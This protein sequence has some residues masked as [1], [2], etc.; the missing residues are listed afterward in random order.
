L[1]PEA[2]LKYGFILISEDVGHCLLTLHIYN[3]CCYADCYL[4]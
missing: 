2:E 4:L 1:D 3:W